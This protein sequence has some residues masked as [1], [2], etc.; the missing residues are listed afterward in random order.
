N[1]VRFE[2]D[3]YML[4][5]KLH[6]PLYLIA[7]VLFGL[8]TYII[9]RFLFNISLE[10]AM[11]ELILFINPI[12]TAFFIFTLSIFFNK[13]RQIKYIKYGILIGSLILYF[14]IVFYRN[15]SDFITI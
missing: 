13:R 12:V 7:A 2:E 9:Y 8:K 15:F 5:K 3:N 10:N 1:S 11:Q 14:N 4:N 6:I